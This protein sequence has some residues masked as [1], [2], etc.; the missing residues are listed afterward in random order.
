MPE[1]LAQL[2]TCT[3]SACTLCDLQNTG[4]S[5]IVFLRNISTVIATV[6]LLWGG[7]LLMTSGGSSD[8]ISKGRKA[9]TAAVIGLAIVWI[10]WL[11]V[12]TFIS[13]LTNFQ[14]RWW[15]GPVLNCAPAS[16]GELPP[17]TKGLGSSCNENNDCQ[18]GNCSD[19]TCAPPDTT[20]TPLAPPCVADFEPCPNS[21]S[22]CC[23]TRSSCG[24]GADG[25]RVC[26]PQ[27]SCVPDFEPCVDGSASRCCNLSSSCGFDRDG[28]FACVPPAP[29]CT[30]G[31][32][33]NGSCG[34]GSCPSI[35]RQ[36]TRTVSPAG[37]ADSSQCI[38]DIGNSCILNSQCCSNNCLANQ[39]CGPPFSF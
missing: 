24:F 30:T 19:G 3:G 35:Q 6:I 18:S 14:G 38:S 29:T 16:L 28:T 25:T 33:I 34:G 37:C 26:L 27:S 10:A 21:S 2:V 9:I 31:L 1:F 36:Q 7:F 5:L 22:V 32:W 4:I 11:A 39:T 23:I 17:K 20:P 15:E 8:R 12:N 13:E